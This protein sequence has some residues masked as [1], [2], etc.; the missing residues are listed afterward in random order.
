MW[1]SN[2]K[3]MGAIHPIP[4]IQVSENHWRQRACRYN[5]IAPF[6][7]LYEKMTSRVYKSLRRKQGSSVVLS[8]QA[9]VFQAVLYSLWSVVLLP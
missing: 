6:I 4:D 5:Y 9:V 3:V 1:S 8:A 7:T 2:R